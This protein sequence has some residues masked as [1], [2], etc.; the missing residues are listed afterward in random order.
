MSIT[1]LRQITPNINNAITSLRQ[2]FRQNRNNVHYAITPNITPKRRC[3]LR[4][5]AK[6]YAKT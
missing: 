1:L 5:Y 2:K 3:P 6:Y 4:Y